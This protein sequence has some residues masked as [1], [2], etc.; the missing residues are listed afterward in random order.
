MAQVGNAFRILV[1]KWCRGNDYKMEMW[2][3]WRY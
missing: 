3:S 2:I 1:I